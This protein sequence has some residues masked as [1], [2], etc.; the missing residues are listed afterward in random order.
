MRPRVAITLRWI[1][2]V[3]PRK[4]AATASNRMWVKAAAGESPGVPH[5]RAAG[6]NTFTPVSA[7]RWA[8]SAPNSWFTD[9]SYPGT[10]PAACWDTV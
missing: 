5:S 8:S 6:P 4:V 2:V 3:P 9:A 7:S 10:P 1:S